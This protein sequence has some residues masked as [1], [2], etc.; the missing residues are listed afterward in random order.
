MKHK[1]STSNTFALDMNSSALY[2]RRKNGAK[3]SNRASSVTKKQH[4]NNT[5]SHASNSEAMTRVRSLELNPFD[6]SRYGTPRPRATQNQPVSETSIHSLCSN[7]DRFAIEQS[8]TEMNQTNMATGSSTPTET[9]PD[10]VTPMPDITNK[11]L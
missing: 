8:N 9:K 1:K 6:F 4:V 10:D 7:F 5:K 3:N 2:N 11:P